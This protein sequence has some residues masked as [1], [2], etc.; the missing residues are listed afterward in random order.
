KDRRGTLGAVNRYDHCGYGKHR[1]RGY[2]VGGETSCESD[3]WFQ[4]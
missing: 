3:N 2:D 4:C 1:D